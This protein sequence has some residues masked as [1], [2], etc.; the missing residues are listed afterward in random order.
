MVNKKVKVEPKGFDWKIAGKKF[1]VNTGI[2]LVSG[3]IAVYQ[4][5]AKYLVFIPLAQAALNY[6]KH[7]KA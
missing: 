3:F 7:R 1:L 6:L 2:V 5:D 4:N